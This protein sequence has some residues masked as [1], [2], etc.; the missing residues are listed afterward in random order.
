MEQE[1][2]RDL[3][4]WRLRVRVDKHLVLVAEHVV[5]DVELVGDGALKETSRA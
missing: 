3:T 1:E 4:L 5:V 2:A